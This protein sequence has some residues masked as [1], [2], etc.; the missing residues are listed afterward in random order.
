MSTLKYLNLC[1]FG[2]F[3]PRQSRKNIIQC[4]LRLLKKIHALHSVQGRYNSG[5]EVSWVVGRLLNR[6][7]PTTIPQ[8][9]EKKEHIETSVNNKNIFCAVEKTFILTLV[10]N[11][12]QIHD[13]GK[14]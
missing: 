1:L 13:L 11:I 2:S 12:P 8:N 9:L 14:K 10:C 4:R 7:F 5:L 3:N 6:D